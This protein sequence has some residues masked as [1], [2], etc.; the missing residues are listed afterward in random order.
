MATDEACTIKK[1]PFRGVHGRVPVSE[2]SRALEL[3][4]TLGQI[5]A[6]VASKRT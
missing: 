1:W 4:R 3:A 6:K 5:M 2:D